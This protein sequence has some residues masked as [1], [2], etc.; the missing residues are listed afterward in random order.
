[1]LAFP[2]APWDRC[3]RPLSIEACPP[4]FRNALPVGFMGADICLG[5]EIAGFLD[6]FVFLRESPL[7]SDIFASSCQFEQLE[8][9]MTVPSMIAID[10][11]A[12]KIR[13]AKALTRRAV[14]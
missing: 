13:H 8:H 5:A 4:A 7:L 6:F 12:A 11:D 1:M 3:G 14:L 9:F 10:V 2:P